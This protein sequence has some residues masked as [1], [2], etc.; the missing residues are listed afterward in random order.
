MAEARELSTPTHSYAAQP[1]EDNLFEWHFT[2][3]GPADTDYA[4]GIYHG[5]I[6]FPPEY[7]YKPPSIMLL[8]PNGR[9]EVNK[10]ICL[11]MSDFHPESW[12]PSW[13]IRT[14]LLAL[15]SFMP[16]PGEGAVG[17]LEVPKAERQKLAASSI[18][19]NCEGCGKCNKD[20][21]AA[22][23]DHDSDKADQAAREV[24]SKLTFRA[25]DRSRNTSLMEDNATTAQPSTPPQTQPTE[26]AAQPPTVTAPASTTAAAAPATTTT[27]TQ[28]AALATPAVAAPLLAPVASIPPPELWKF[29]AF[30]FFLIGTIFFLFL[31]PHFQQQEPEF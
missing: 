23:D 13:S 15:I 2:I 22:K 24:A 1:L 20:I 25:A 18:E 6:I 31:R 12:Q 28:T 29:D 14:V 5:R 17:A 21:L 16:T 8:T 26:F 30:I 7:P 11:S 4:G 19:W 27:T 9:F 3:R 10:R